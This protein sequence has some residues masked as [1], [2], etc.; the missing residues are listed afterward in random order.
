VP[1]LSEVEDTIAVPIWRRLDTEVALLAF[2]RMLF[3]RENNRAA[4]TATMVITTSISI[5][6]KAAWKR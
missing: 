2:L 1:L 5:K 6:V 4:R 3:V